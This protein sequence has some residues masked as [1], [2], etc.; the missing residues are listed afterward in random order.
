MAH[1]EMT[2]LI[3]SK[4]RVTLTVDQQAHF[5]VQSKL[6]RNRLFG[7]SS[8]LIDCFSTLC[9]KRRCWRTILRFGKKD[10]VLQLQRNQHLTCYWFFYMFWFIQLYSFVDKLN[11]QFYKLN[12]YQKYITESKNKKYRYMKIFQI[13]L[14]FK[15]MVQYKSTFLLMNLRSGL[16]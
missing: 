12:W 11:K 6:S 16:V 15:L 9:W 5:A 13:F 14:L 4:R 7:K 10:V 3:L 2:A 8:A 1:P